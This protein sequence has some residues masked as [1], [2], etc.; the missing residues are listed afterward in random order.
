MKPDAFPADNE[1]VLRLGP[2]NLDPGVI[3]TLSWRTFPTSGFYY[4]FRHLGDSLAIWFK[5]LGACTLKAI[6]IHFGAVDA[7]NVF[8]DVYES[9]YSGHIVTT[10][11]TDAFGWIGTH[12][13]GQWVPGW[14]MGH[15]P[16]GE[17]I[18]GPFP[19]S[20]LES[21]YGTWIE[22][23]TS[24]LGEPNL[25]GKPFFV[26]MMLAPISYLTIGFEREN[27]VPYHLFWYYAD[28]CGLDGVHDGWFIRSFS[29]WVEAIVKYYKNTPP[30]ISDMDVLNYT[31]APGPF[32][33][34]ARIEDRDAED[35]G[36]AGVVSA[37]LHWDINGVS[38]SSVMSGPTEGGTF[39]GQIP[40]IVWGDVVRYYISAIDEAGAGSSNVPR[41]F[42]RLKPTHPDADILL[43]D[44]G[45]YEDEPQFYRQLLDSLGYL[46]EYWSVEKRQGIDE[47][48][49]SYGWRT[50]IIFGY[51][52]R[53]PPS[54]RT[55]PLPTREYGDN[56][57]A[58]FLNA[59]TPEIPANL[60]YAENWYSSLNWEDCQ[61]EFQPGDFAYDYFGCAAVEE[62]DCGGCTDKI[63]Y[64]LPA[65]P[66]SGDF[67]E[68]PLEQTWPLPFRPEYWITYTVA[69]ETG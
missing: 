36:R 39:T 29:L 45:V 13:D 10:D 12:E 35:P 60:F 32:S 57:W 4:L 56:I 64:G 66:I 3:D 27:T 19:L 17:H 62:C 2:L 58:D 37:Y 7:G 1:A 48:V 15:S 11:S 31:Y 42:A 30:K 23:P 6:R 22:I 33:V 38:D 52:S 25:N 65:D 61:P 28:C 43:V 51:N 47:S 34:R 41:T 68:D 18:W 5:P 53:R 16:L 44:Y 20:V 14:V 63:L 26:T 46:Y 49:S 67:A 8:L 21:E 24:Y 54:Y 69:A 40:P 55:A 9:R 59:G 50:A